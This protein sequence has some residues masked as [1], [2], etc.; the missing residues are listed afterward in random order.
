MEING[1]GFI[2]LNRELMDHWIHKDAQKYQ[3]WI[4]MIMLVNYTEEKVVVGNQLVKCG[5]GQSVKSLSSWGKIF[6]VSKD[7]VRNF[8]VLLEKDRMITRET[9]ASGTRSITRITICNYER[10]KGILHAGH[11]Q[12]VR[13][14]NANKKSEK[15]KNKGENAFYDSNMKYVNS[16]DD[17][18]YNDFLQSVE[19]KYK[20]CF[21]NMKLPE[22]STYYQ[23]RKQYSKELI[24]NAAF[25]QKIES[26]ETFHVDLEAIIE[27]SLETKDKLERL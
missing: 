5:I 21:A 10:Y 22:E 6:G 25:S 24:L 14:I 19:S 12:I 23:W 26:A 13:N 15:R 11:P 27:S 2:C 1:K 18:E 9:L 8:F 7:T 17:E 20:S 4:D 3:W 16:Q